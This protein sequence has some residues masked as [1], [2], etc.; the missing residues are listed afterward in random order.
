M[1]AA[2]AATVTA[3]CECRLRGKSEHDQRHAE[4]KRT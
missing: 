3:G 2:S 4:Q 1:E